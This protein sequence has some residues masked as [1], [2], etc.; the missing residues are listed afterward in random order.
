M[1]LSLGSGFAFLQI[2]NLVL[3][4]EGRFDNE[5]LIGTKW[6]KYF[7]RSDQ[8]YVEEATSNLSTYLHFLLLS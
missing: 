3:A 2:L 4:V 5:A 6:A 7:Q 1:G 8:T